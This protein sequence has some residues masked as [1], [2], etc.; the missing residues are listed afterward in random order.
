MDDSLVISLII[1]VITL[2]AGVISAVI[3]IWYKWNS[4][5]KY[6]RVIPFV[7]ILDNLV[8]DIDLRF[9]AEAPHWYI[10]KDQ[11]PKYTKGHRC[12]Y[13]FIRTIDNYKV[14]DCYAQPRVYSN[15]HGQADERQTGFNIGM[16]SFRRV[17]VLAM[18][19]E[20]QTSIVLTLEYETECGEKL[21]YTIEGKVDYAQ[22]GIKDRVDILYKKRK[23]RRSYKKLR[24]FNR[25]LA[26][27]YSAKMIKAF[28]NGKSLNY[29]DVSKDGL[30][31][32][33]N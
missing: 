10:R 29:K 16:L 21:R 18:P 27:S 5:K 24:E 26:E 4:E 2:A 7:A 28:I 23:C 22:G 1:A 17:A 8:D 6:K 19:I 31:D 20:R 9:D 3:T 13:F 11:I 15:E 12:V 32:G 25:G 14:I 30:E 33:N